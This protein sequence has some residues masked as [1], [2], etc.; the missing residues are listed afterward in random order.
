MSVVKFHVFGRA[1]TEFDS[2]LAGLA[3][4]MCQEVIEIAQ[5]LKCNK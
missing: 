1:E 4:K 2:D 5:I 3:Q